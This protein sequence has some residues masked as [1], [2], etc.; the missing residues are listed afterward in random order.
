VSTYPARK[1]RR[2]LLAKGFKQTQTHHEMYWLVVH[3]VK[4]PVHTYLNH[5]NIDYGLGLT[6]LIAREPHLR[7]SELDAFVRCPL[8]GEKYVELLRQRGAI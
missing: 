6:S 3:G 2:A 4:T 1:I 7:R 5:G 8:D